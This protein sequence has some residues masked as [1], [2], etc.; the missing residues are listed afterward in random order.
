[1]QQKSLEEYR[2]FIKSFTKLHNDAKK[3]PLGESSP[4]DLNSNPDFKVLIFSPHPD[5]ECVVGAL[6]L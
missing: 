1:M 3:I 5:D 6:P 2:K 4:S